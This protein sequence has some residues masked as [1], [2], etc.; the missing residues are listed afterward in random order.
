[1]SGP[2]PNLQGRSYLWAFGLY[3]VLFFASAVFGGSLGLGRMWSAVL[4]ALAG[5]IPFLVQGMTGYALD[6]SWRARFSR[7]EHPTRFRVMLLLSL[8]FAGLFTYI[9]YTSYVAGV[10]GRTAGNIDGDKESANA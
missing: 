2:N 8:I 7:T 5:F 3:V 4:L 10:P 1:M 9:A 6:G